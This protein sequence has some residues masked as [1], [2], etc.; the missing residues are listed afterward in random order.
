MNK[1]VVLNIL[2]GIM[3]I[4]PIISIEDIVPW[5]VALFFIHR[6]IKG[7]KIKDELKPIL[8]NT[9][10]CGGIILV[11]N[12]LARYIESALIKAWM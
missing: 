8:L 11:Y 7:F 5:V 10:Y 9:L 3:F 2:I 6:S 12:V 1:K 4:M